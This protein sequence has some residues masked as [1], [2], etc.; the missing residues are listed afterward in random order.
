M[1]ARDGGSCGLP[2]PEEIPGCGTGPLGRLR[3]VVG[4][5]VG[6]LRRRPSSPHPGKPT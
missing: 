5:L 3:W 6:I 1:S 4:E 2:G